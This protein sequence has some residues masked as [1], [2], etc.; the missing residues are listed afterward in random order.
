MADLKT[1][2]QAVV[3]KLASVTGIGK[4]Q[5][6]E[7]YAKRNSDMLALYKEGS[8]VLGWYV[9]RTKTSE[10]SDYPGRWDR[11]YSWVIRGFMGLDDS[12]QT[13]LLFDDLIE[14]SCAAFRDDDT[15]GGVVDTCIIGNEAGIQVQDSGPVMFAGVLCHSATL[16][17]NTRVWL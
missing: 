2:K 5:G 7:R 4:V 6:Y 3:D 10:S 16:A 8:Q 13:E 9:R 17:L 15:L 11:T 14:A 1:V 12:E